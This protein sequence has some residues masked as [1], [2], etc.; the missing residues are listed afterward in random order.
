MQMRTIDIGIAKRKEQVRHRKI[1]IAL[2]WMGSDH[3]IGNVT[4]TA[5]DHENDE[6]MT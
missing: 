6:T 5:L 3:G 2:M 4:D 1:T